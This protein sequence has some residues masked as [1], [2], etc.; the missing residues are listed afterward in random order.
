M[1][2]IFDQCYFF[3]PITSGIL[4]LLSLNTPFDNDTYGSDVEPPELRGNI[5]IDHGG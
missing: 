4:V 5:M 2:M 1:R 3:L